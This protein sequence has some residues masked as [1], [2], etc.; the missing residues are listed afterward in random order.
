M[1][2]NIEAEIDAIRDE[3]YEET[4]NMTRSERTAYFN[5]LADQARREYGFL[6]KGK[7]IPAKRSQ[8]LTS[9]LEVIN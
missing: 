2:R 6:A 5:S 8:D 4:K 7:R 1:N 3:L 9:V